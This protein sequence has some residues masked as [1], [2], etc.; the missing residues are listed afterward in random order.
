MRTWSDRV[1]LGIASIS[2]LYV[3]GFLLARSLTRGQAVWPASSID[4]YL[5]RSRC[6]RIEGALSQD[7][8]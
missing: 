6:S 3:A 5:E 8:G 1:A 4:E 2:A 7:S